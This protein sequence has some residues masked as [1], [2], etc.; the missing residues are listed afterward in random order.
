MNILTPTEFA[1]MMGA[2]GGIV[3]AVDIVVK[4]TGAKDWLQRRGWRLK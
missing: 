4:K 1:L 2:I 3:Y